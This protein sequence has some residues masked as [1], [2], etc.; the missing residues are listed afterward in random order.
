MATIYLRG[1][2]WYLSWS[3]NGRQVRQ[4]LGSIAASAAETI[5]SAKEAELEHGVRILPRL[6]TVQQFMDFYAEWYKADHPTTHKGLL[7]EIKPF[8]RTF[9]H[10]P[11]DTIRAAEVEAWKADRLKTHARE[12]VGKELRRFKAAFKRGIAWGE[13]DVNPVEHVQA[14]RGVRSVAVRFYT[15]AEV[16]KLSKTRRGPLWRF[17]ACTGLRRSEAVRVVQSLHVVADGQM[18]VIRV[19]SDPDATGAGR[20]KSGAWREIPLNAAAEASLMELPDRIAP[21]HPDTLGDW[22]AADAREAGVGG[23]LHRLR[24]TFCAHLAMAGVPL[25]RIQLLAGHADQKTTEM[26]AHLSPDG[27]PEAVG[28]LKF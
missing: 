17:L 10:R 23:S 19:E 1:K 6:P 21:C 13:L 20:T 9:G 22:F 16:A 4:S 12:T 5:R 2:S 3:E 7:K 15:V 28:K 14:P 18:T 27:A 25:R 24:H 26:Y 8:L 11:I